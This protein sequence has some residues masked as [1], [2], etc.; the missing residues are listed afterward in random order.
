MIPVWKLIASITASF[1]WGGGIVSSSHPTNG[2][3]K[4]RVSVLPFVSDC[5][6]ICKIGGNVGYQ[7]SKTIQLLRVPPQ[8]SIFRGL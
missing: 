3:F 2:G 8:S 5:K 6:N 4:N 1:N 7:I